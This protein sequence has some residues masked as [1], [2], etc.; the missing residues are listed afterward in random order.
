MVANNLSR[1]EQQGLPE[2]V[3]R[4]LPEKRSDGRASANRW[5][6]WEPLRQVG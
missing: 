4:G 6:I 3:A 5:H 2:V 1:A